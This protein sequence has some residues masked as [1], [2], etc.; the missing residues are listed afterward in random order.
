MRG[1][2]ELQIEG[3]V[4]AHEDDME[5]LQRAHGGFA[6]LVVRNGAG[7]SQWPKTAVGRAATDEEVVQFHVIDFVPA[8]LR[9]EHQDKRCVL[10]N[11]DFFNG[12][13][14]DPDLQRSHSCLRVLAANL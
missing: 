14:D 6:Q 13:H 3:R 10:V 2:L 9:F 7:D 4:F 5:I 1:K 11:I 12:V 8:P